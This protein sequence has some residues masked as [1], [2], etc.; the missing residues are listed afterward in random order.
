M[1][2]SI[3]FRRIV[4]M[5]IITLALIVSL[6]DRVN[7]FRISNVIVFSLLGFIFLY[8]ILFEKSKDIEQS[9]YIR[10]MQGKEVML[11]VVS[12]VLIVCWISSQLYTLFS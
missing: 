6:V 11:A 3:L 4:F 10:N 2:E 5:L 1:R 9:T 8:K 7:G 12:L